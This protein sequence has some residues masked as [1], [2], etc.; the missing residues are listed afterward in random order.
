MSSSMWPDGR[1][2]CN[3]LQA[4][5]SSFQA[6]K[7]VSFG[8]SLLA[9][10]LLLSKWHEVSTSLQLLLNIDRLLLADQSASKSV[11]WPPVPLDLLLPPANETNFGPESMESNSSMLMSHMHISL[12][13]ELNGDQLLRQEV[14]SFTGEPASIQQKVVIRNFELQQR[15]KL[16]NPLSPKPNPSDWIGAAEFRNAKSTLALSSMLVSIYIISWILMTLAIN[17]TRISVSK[18]KVRGAH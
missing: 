12:S 6:W 10:V 14:D 2:I 18:Q 5:K 17:D 11:S 8:C 15:I 7:C 1:P 3:K 16:E 9:I 4:Q 13:R